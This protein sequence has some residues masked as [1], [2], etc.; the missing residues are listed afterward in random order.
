MFWFDNWLSYDEQSS[1]CLYLCQLYDCI[2]TPVPDGSNMINGKLISRGDNE[3]I[4]VCL[5][6][7]SPFFN[8]NDIYSDRVVQPD[9]KS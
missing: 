2:V 4:S 3:C 5:V 7:L 8:M 1:I 6:M 9:T